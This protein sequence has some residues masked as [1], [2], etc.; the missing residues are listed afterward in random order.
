[1]K[2]KPT[3]QRTTNEETKNQSATL[4]HSGS[5][6]PYSGTARAYEGLDVAEESLTAVEGAGRVEA[7]AMSMIAP[8]G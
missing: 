7:L 8:R 3:S 4:T 2:Q 6:E 1:M 5:V